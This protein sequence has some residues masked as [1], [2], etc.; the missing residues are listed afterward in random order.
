[1]LC[2][3]LRKHLQGAKLCDVRQ[4]GF[5]RVAT[6]EFETRDEMGFACVR[7]L[8]AEVMGKYSN[9]I[10]TDGDGKVMAAR[11]TTTIIALRERKRAVPIRSC[12]KKAA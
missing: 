2:M 12:L 8:I 5:E 4:E 6:L 10:F 9:L 7:R 1:M 3:L 11:S